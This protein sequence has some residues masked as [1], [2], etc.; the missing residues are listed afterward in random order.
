MREASKRKE[1]VARQEERAASG[2]VV[3]A[4]FERDP[5]NYGEAM[6]NS[7]RAE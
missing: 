6:H 7:K 3:S 4:A 1:V 5:R 2:E